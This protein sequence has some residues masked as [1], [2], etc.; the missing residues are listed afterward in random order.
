MP[1]KKQSDV[2]GGDSETPF[3]KSRPAR[4]KKSISKRDCDAAEH[5]TVVAKEET[6]ELDVDKTVFDEFDPN[7]DSGLPLRTLINFTLSKK[8]DPSQLL[9]LDDIES[10]R[11]NVTLRGT[12]VEPLPLKWRE[13]MVALLSTTST[14]ES[15]TSNS[16]DIDVNFG[17]ISNSES[18]KTPG[19]TKL[20]WETLRVN[21]LVDG[22]CF[23]TYKW[24]EAKIVQYD[25]AKKQYKVHFQGWN[26][27][28]DEWIDKYSE[29]LVP[30][31]A[32]LLLLKE[33][34]KQAGFMLPW[35]QADDLQSRAASKIG[36]IILNR[37]QLDI[38]IE[39][40]DDWCM[41]LT[42]AN[43]TL[44]IISSL[45]IWYRVAGALCPG[46]HSNGNPSDPYKPFF[47]PTLEK[48]LASA[49]VA[50]AILDVFPSMPTAN[51]QVITEEISSRTKGL[52]N[53]LY[54]LEHYKFVAEQLS[55]LQLPE[56][57]SSKISI[58]KS[59]FMSQLMKEGDAF[60]SCGGMIALRVSILLFVFGSFLSYQCSIEWYLQGCRYQKEERT[61]TRYFIEGVASRT[62][63]GA[64]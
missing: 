42:Y 64:L 57:W 24:Y 17:D 16:A 15:S 13:T 48:Y 23:Q 56:G 18:N 10:N 5:I 27:K 14:D 61:H 44:W 62:N 40:V 58:V 31:K 38:V 6:L 25:D 32:S 45:G 20:D 4:S 33:A 7:D 19:E 37:K 55:S 63:L 59:V 29:R 39:D 54:I 12:L 34:E 35:Y 53:E 28:F 22:Y 49:H 30:H 51:F 46:G 21:D 50:M 8:D 1:G 52:M 60:H 11:G 36:K 41:D 2:A 43:P 26:S 9:T 3:T 47:Q